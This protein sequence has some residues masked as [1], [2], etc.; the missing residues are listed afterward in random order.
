M[1]VLPII[2]GFFGFFC[3]VLYSTISFIPYTSSNYLT[4]KKYFLIHGHSNRIKGT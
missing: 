2:I 1:P 4:L 3:L